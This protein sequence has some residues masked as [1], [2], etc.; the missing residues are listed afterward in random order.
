MWRLININFLLVFVRVKSALDLLFLIIKFVRVLHLCYKF[1]FHF[2]LKPLL[3]FQ[4][5]VLKIKIADIRRIIKR[6]FLLRHVVS[7]RPLY[8]WNRGLFQFVFKERWSWTHIYVSLGQG[9]TFTGVRHSFC[10]RR[11]GGGCWLPSPRGWG[12][13][14]WPPSMDHRSHGQGGLHPGEFLHLRR[15]GVWGSAFRGSASKGYA[16]R[17]GLHP[18][19][20]SSE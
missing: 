3:I 17:R 11:W 7:I 18:G 14:C 13:G 2:L 16:S 5:P 20:S 4:L 1:S 12:G 6:R 10:P 15:G 8:M 9:N 19:G